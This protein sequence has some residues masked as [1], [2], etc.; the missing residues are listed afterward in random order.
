MNRAQEPA[1]VKGRL[2][3]GQAVR[4]AAVR[5][6]GRPNQQPK[7]LRS[8]QHTWQAVTHGG[9]YRIQQLSARAATLHRFV[10]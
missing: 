8:L 10:A 5:G 9:K 6:C 1:P 7:V 2:V 3:A 4:L